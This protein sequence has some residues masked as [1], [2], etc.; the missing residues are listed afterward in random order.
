MKVEV[1][2]DFFNLCLEFFVRRRTDA[3][4]A[5]RLRPKKSDLVA[6]IT[7]GGQT[8]T[9]TTKNFEELKKLNLLSA[10]IMKICTNPEVDA[11]DF[12]ALQQSVLNELSEIDKSHCISVFP[13]FVN[14]VISVIKLH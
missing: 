10:M 6:R 4:F 13:P 7:D 3:K 2:E 5:L 11:S 12:T 8:F 9:F 1:L 14:I